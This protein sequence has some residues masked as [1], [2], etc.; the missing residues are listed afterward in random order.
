LFD[1]TNGKGGVVAKGKG[2]LELGQSGGEIV[3]AKV[4]KAAR[5]HGQHYRR[6]RLLGLLIGQDDGNTRFEA[7]DRLRILLRSPLCTSQVDL[8]LQNKANN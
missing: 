4:G 3:R 5:E 1:E 8:G 6:E 2:L 7:S